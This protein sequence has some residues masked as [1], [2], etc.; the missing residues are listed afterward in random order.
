MI[1]PCTK[2]LEKQKLTPPPHNALSHTKTRVSPKYPANDCRPINGSPNH[3]TMLTQPWRRPW[4]APRFQ[5]FQ[6]KNP[7]LKQPPHLTQAHILVSLGTKFQLKMTIF[8]DQIFRKTLFLVENEKTEQHLWIVYIR[9]KLATKFS[10]KLTILITLNKFAKKEYSDRKQKK[11]EQN[12]CF[13]HIRIRLATKF[14]LKEII[15]IF[16]TKFA[17]KRYF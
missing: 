7:S 17:Q 4:P 5:P 3:H 16:W 9:I 14:Q 13:L 15:L 6:V 12:F 11:S 8:F 1:A 2:T 10:L